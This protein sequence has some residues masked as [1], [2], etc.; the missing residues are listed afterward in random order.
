M[1][2]H[3][4]TQSGP[5]VETLPIYGAVSGLNCRYHEIVDD[6]MDE[7]DLLPPKL[8]PIENWRVNSRERARNGKSTCSNQL[9][10]Q[11]D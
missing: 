8:L 9:Q 5:L 3:L 7:D 10:L 6:V 4:D 2:M 1:V 11:L